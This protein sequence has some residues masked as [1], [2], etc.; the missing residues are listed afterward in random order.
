M[1]R[2]KVIEIHQGI[3]AQSQKYIDFIERVPLH[4]MI[5]ITCHTYPVSLHPS[6]HPAGTPWQSIKRKGTDI[7]CVCKVFGFNKESIR[8]SVIAVEHLFFPLTEL[9]RKEERQKQTGEMKEITDTHIKLAVIKDFTWH[10]VTSKELPLYVHYDYKTVLFEKL[11]KG[12]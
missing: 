12:E 7:H 8:V 3:I 1:K 2:E 5:G 10:E 4:Q 11:M 9:P 6:P